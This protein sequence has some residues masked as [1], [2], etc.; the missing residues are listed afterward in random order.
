MSKPEVLMIGAYPAW[1]T[2]DLDARYIVHKL[3]EAADRD[4]MIDANRGAIRAI[5]TRGELAHP[6]S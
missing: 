2:E 6:Q 5:A 1:D 3:W 4:R